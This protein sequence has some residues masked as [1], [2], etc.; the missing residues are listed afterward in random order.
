VRVEDPDAMRA[1]L[2][3]QSWDAVTSDWSM[4]S[5]SGLSASGDSLE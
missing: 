1:A 4:P 3:A 5:F 2:K